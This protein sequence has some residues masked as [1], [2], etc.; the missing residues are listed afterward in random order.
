MSEAAF[1]SFTFERPG[2]KNLDEVVERTIAKCPLCKG[3]H[4]LQKCDTFRRLKPYRR[5][6]AVKKHKYCANCL[7]QSNFSKNCRSR[8]RC[9]ECRGIH[10]TMLHVYRRDDENNK[11]VGQRK[12]NNKSTTRSQVHECFC[13]TRNNT[14]NNCGCETQC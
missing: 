3:Q 14:N 11:R 12:I 13:Q 2:S 5:L 4:I 8:E 1:K 6:R 9:R 7:A 10:H